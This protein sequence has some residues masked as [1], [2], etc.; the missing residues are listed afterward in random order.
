MAGDVAR[1]RAQMDLTSMARTTSF[2]A[3][4][5]ARMI[6]R[7]EVAATGVRTPEQLVTGAL[8]DRLVR[9]LAAFR[10]GFELTEERV[11]RL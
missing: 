3:A 10:V 2:T 11:E 7:G 6:A 8:C 1:R 9:E 5:V 4:I